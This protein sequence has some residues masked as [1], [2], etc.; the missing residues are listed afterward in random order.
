[1]SGLL[2]DLIN[3]EK[4]FVIVGWC[5]DSLTIPF[6]LYVLYK[7]TRGKMW[8]LAMLSLF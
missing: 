2:D 1:M 8:F 3:G 7:T 6:G 5:A 4:P